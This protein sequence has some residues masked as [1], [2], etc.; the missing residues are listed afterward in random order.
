MV[1][2][3]I[4][5]LRRIPADCHFL[6]G[7]GVAIGCFVA[8]A[9][10]L[11]AVGATAVSG[12]GVVDQLL[13]DMWKFPCRYEEILSIQFVLENKILKEISVLYVNYF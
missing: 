10:A 13:N 1:R 7:A 8:T 4:A 6:S 11:S 2:V 12:F 9:L 5:F 3:V